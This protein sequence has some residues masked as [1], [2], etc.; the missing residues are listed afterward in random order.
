M[1]SSVPRR[2]QWGSESI[3]QKLQSKLHR[4]C[5]AELEQQLLVGL[6]QWGIRRHS[7]LA[8][9]TEP[10][11]L[12]LQQAEGFLQK[13]PVAHKGCDPD[14]V[15]MSFPQLCIPKVPNWKWLHNWLG[16]G[17]LFHHVH[18]GMRF[19]SHLNTAGC[20]ETFAVACL[21][22]EHPEFPEQCTSSQ[23]GS[24]QQVPIQAGWVCLEEQ[25]LLQCKRSQMKPLLQ[26]N[27]ASL[28]H[29]SS[30]GSANAES[31]FFFL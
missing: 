6:L 22:A 18:C 12:K 9:S 7:A 15:V 14:V 19:S 26:C 4:Q 25:E 5:P 16:H 31:C 27:D 1:S 29:K 8:Q 10:Q 13:L 17:Q 28:L 30:P 20:S 24:R 23:R 11:Q 21:H 3:T 2:L